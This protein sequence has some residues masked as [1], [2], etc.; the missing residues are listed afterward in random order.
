MASDTDLR[1]KN[2]KINQAKEDSL[3]SVNGSEELELA[4]YRTYAAVS[5]LQFK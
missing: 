4:W 1:E 5:L 3:K 2:S